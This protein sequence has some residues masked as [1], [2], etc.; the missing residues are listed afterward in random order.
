MSNLALAKTMV[1]QARELVA[2][3]RI[4]T[5]KLGGVTVQAQAVQK[6]EGVELTFM[7]ETPL[8][9]VGGKLYAPQPTFENMLVAA[10][11]SDVLPRARQ[12]VESV[13]YSSEPRKLLTR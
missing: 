8:G 1:A 2:S 5:V 13:E 6:E 3:E 7:A 10:S 9:P 4:V 11:M 12:M